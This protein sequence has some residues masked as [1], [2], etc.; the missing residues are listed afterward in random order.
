MNFSDSYDRFCNSEAYDGENPDCSKNTTNFLRLVAREGVVGTVS[1]LI[2]I[3]WW[4]ERKVLL[5]NGTCYEFTRQGAD[6]AFGNK[7]GFLRWVEL[8]I[9]EANIKIGELN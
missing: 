4:M 8:N 2:D 7:A 9:N 1:H 3:N 6:E 5:P